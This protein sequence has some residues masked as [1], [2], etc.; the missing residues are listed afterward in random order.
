MTIYDIFFF[1]FSLVY[2]PY[3]IIKGKAHKDFPERLGVLPDKVKSMASERPIWIHAVSVGEVLAVKEFITKLK[4]DFPEKKVVLSTTTKTGNDVAEKVLKDVVRFYFPL[5][6]SFIVRRVIKLINPSYFIM[7][8]TEIWPNLTLELAKQKVPIVLI[9]GRIS[10][11]SF[12]GYV[13]I[14]PIFSK[15]LEK[16]TLL[17]MRTNADADRIIALGAR[18]ENV[19]VTGNMKFDIEI[20][21]K[22]IPSIPGIDSNSEL[23]IAGSTHPGE[24]E[25]VLSAYGRLKKECENLKLLIA[26]RHIERSEDLKKLVEK[27]GFEAILVSE[28]RKAP[29]KFENKK[30]IFVLDTLGELGYLYSFATVVFIGG[31]LIKRG[32]HNIVEPAIFGKPILFGHYMFNFTDMAK[33]FIEN[34]AAIEV[35]KKE[36]LFSEFSKI[37]SDKKKREMLGANARDLIIKSKG[38]ISNNVREFSQIFREE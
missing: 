24:E 17:C 6:F 36:E 10:N 1:V 8:E 38:A 7:M 22:E 11:K 16:I 9:N 4:N 35:R 14:K 20:P 19:K 21:K 28:A 5:D 37:L 29:G 30:V 32:G 25:L 27:K 3:L 15:I 26:P 18:K 12:S 31:S 13:K 23:L 34:K 33:S 2:L